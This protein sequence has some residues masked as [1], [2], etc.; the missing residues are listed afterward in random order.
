MGTLHVVDKH[1]YSRVVGTGG[2]GAKMYVESCASLSVK[3][4]MLEHE[5][6]GGAV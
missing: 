5:G 2:G 6:G 1:T 4:T 3:T